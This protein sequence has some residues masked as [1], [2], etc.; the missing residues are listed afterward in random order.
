MF[1]S[2]FGRNNKFWLS[3]SKEKGQYLNNRYDCFY[4]VTTSHFQ[5]DLVDNSPR[6][7]NWDSHILS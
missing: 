5:L 2:Y 6:M 7:I 3:Y 4:C 1:M